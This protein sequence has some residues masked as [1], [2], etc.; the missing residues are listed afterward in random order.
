MKL[1]EEFRV[2]QPVPTVWEFFEQPEL[3]A[4][5]VPG[6][7]Q[8]RVIDVDN[9]DVRA[10]QSIG[11]MNATFE[12]KVTVLER[13][14]N[15]YIRFQAVGRSVRGAVGNV[16][17]SNAVRLQPS[18]GS[19]TVVVE[20][21]VVLAG[22]LGSVGQKIVAKQASK[23]TASFAENLRLALNGEQPTVGTTG[24]PTAPTTS[25]TAANAPGEWTDARPPGGKTSTTG[26]G[27]Q[28][29]RAAA[30][31]SALSAVLSV[32]VLIRLRRGRP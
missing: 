14:P 5:C 30:A 29:T 17:T 24:I 31:L 9:V 16:R 32:V 7:E 20:G 23:V 13:V 11:P 8:I 12:A 19:T 1:R 22:A 3:V 4:R 28:W 25:G 21:D 26:S 10:T 6:V 27:D 15:E 2:D 18:E